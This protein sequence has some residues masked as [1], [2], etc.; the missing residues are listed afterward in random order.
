MNSCRIGHFAGN[1]EL[2]LCEHEAGINVPKQSYADLFFMDSNV[3]CNN[4]LAT[5]WPEVLRIYPRLI[6]FPVHRIN[7]FIPGWRSHEIGSNTQSDRD[8]HDLY[9]Q[10]PP[11]LMFTGDELQKGER[12]IT[13]NGDSE[14]GSFRLFD[15]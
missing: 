2:Y 12:A 9:M 3:I 4:Q 13:N 1:T 15:G 14:G 5:M 10:F 11:H 8:V 7:R 6:L